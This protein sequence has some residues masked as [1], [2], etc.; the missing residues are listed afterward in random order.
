[1][2]GEFLW[3]GILEKKGNDFF[4]RWNKRKV[5]IVNNECQYFDSEGVNV[6]GI[7]SIV[8]S[9]TVSTNGNIVTIKTIGRPE[10]K[11]GKLIALNNIDQFNNILSYNRGEW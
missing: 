3:E 10:K 1:M 7:I 2:S 9:T 4:S 5:I 6:K 8:S 11:K